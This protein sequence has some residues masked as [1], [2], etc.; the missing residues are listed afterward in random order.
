MSDK[1]C[2]L[3]PRVQAALTIHRLAFWES[4]LL[5]WD[6]EIPESVEARE[7][8]YDDEYQ[9]R[10]ESTRYNDISSEDYEA[11]DYNEGWENGFYE[12]VAAFGGG[13]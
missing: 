3:P 2:T 11:I 9:K 6:I 10:C 12:A 13:A 7:K 8:A 1:T 4:M 5:S